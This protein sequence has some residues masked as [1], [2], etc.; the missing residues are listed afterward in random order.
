MVIIHAGPCYA[1]HTHTRL[2][3]TALSIP[4]GTPKSIADG[5]LRF[6]ESVFDYVCGAA[7][8]SPYFVREGKEHSK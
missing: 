8:A 2:S 3:P 6:G 7:Y 5:Y 1:T 4:E